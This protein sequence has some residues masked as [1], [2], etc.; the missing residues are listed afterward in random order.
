M[1]LAL[2]NTADPLLNKI[3]AVTGFSRGPFATVAV[4]GQ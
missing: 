3:L 4:L 1:R 2:E